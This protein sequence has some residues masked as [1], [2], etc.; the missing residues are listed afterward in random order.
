MPLS[1]HKYALFKMNCLITWWYWLPQLLKK[2]NR[3]VSAVNLRRRAE[4]RKETTVAVMQQK[5]CHWK[6]RRL[7]SAKRRRIP[8]CHWI[9]GFLWQK[10]KSLC[11]SCSTVTANYFPAGFLF[12]DVFTILSVVYTIWHLGRWV[13]VDGEKCFPC[14]T[15]LSPIDLEIIDRV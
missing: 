7:N 10:M 3:F 12:R 15:G 2:S 1:R 9:L 14:A 4:E 5:K 8:F 13:P 11:Y 6:E